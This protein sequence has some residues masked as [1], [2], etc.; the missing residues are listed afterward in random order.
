VFNNGEYQENRMNSARYQGRMA[1]TGK[2][3]GV[4]FGHPD[5][6]YVSMSSSN[7]ASTA[8]ILIGMSSSRSQG[9]FPDNPDPARQIFVGF[10]QEFDCRALI[11]HVTSRSESISYIAGDARGI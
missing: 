6:N 9:I 7:V 8:K 4:N 1:E 3:L 11:A 5:I 10:H 2:F